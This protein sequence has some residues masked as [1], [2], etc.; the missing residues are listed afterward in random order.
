MQH[1]FLPK[2]PIQSVTRLINLDV[3]VIYLLPLFIHPGGRLITYQWPVTLPSCYPSLLSSLP[4][5]HPSLRV[6]R[7]TRS[8]PRA[9]QRQ[10]MGDSSH[11]LVTT[12][13][14]RRAFS[15][16]TRVC[17]YDK[18][19]VCRE[20]IAN[21]RP[22]RKQPIRER[23]RRANRK[24]RSNWTRNPIEKDWRRV[25]RWR[26]QTNNQRG[27]IKDNKKRTNSQRKY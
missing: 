4:C 10:I 16:R 26:E 5:P 2:L 18:W 12:E 24:E 22:E 25:M 20:V 1:A 14:M 9:R 3:V 23:R 11:A 15:A 8:S 7:Q 27:R 6:W 17:V 19:C 13:G 21:R